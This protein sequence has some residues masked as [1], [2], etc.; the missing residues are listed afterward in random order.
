M[1]VFVVE[2]GAYSDRYVYGVFSTEERA[3]IAAAP[4]GDVTEYQLDEAFDL[5]DKGLRAFDV[6]IAYDGTIK[7]ISNLDYRA[8]TSTQSRLLASGSYA[9][10]RWDSLSVTTWAKDEQ[11]AAKIANEHRAEVIAAGW[12][13]VDHF[14]LATPRVS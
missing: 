4:N 6:A 3:R 13:G 10:L 9:N 7:G 11:H 1:K 8:G 12:N 5:Y 14:C 2:F